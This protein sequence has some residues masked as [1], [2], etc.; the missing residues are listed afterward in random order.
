MSP[1]IYW[2][3]A[4]S[5]NAGKTT[6]SS[7]LVSVLAERSFKP[8]AFKP[9]S[10]SKFVDIMDLLHERRHM[11]TARLFGSDGAKLIEASPCLNPQDADLVQPII[12]V[13]FPEFE[14]PIMARV[15]S[16]QAGDVRYIKTPFSVGLEARPDYAKMLECLGLDNASLK[17]D[18]RELRFAQTPALSNS[19]VEACF[20]HLVNTHQPTHVVCEGA[21][22]FAP[23]WHAQRLVHHV[24]YLQCNE[25]FFYPNANLVLPLNPASSLVPVSEVLTRL[26]GRP[27]RR[28]LLPLALSTQRTEIAKT[29]V[30][31][32]LG[33]MPMDPALVS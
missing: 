16:H 27:C 14:Q 1:Q 12:L 13:Y 22:S 7:A 2:V 5:T 28:S 21:S 4:N 19:S 8:V 31:Q 32:M 20:Q 24:V 29:A 3:V 9:Y 26:R 6:I 11:T 15:G 10:G 23:F 17:F 25:L 30:R 18:I 33:A